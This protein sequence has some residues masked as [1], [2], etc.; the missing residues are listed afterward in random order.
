LN[1]QDSSGA[2]SSSNI[3]PKDIACNPGYYFDYYLGKCVPICPAGYHNDSITGACVLNAP[4]YVSY[5][6]VRIGYYIGNHTL[7]FSSVADV[8]TVLNQLDSDYEQYNTAYEN[9]YPNYNPNQ[10]DSIDSINNF[11][12]LLTYE[13]FE[14]NFSGYISERSS[15]YNIEST[16]L[17]NNMEGIDPDSIDLTYDNSENAICNNTYMVMIAGSTYQW[18]TSGFVQTGGAMSPQSATTCFTNRTKW[19]KPLV[20]SNRAFR[21]KAAINYYIVR[22]SAHGKVV[23]YKQSNGKWKRSRYDLSVGVAGTIYAPDCS[24][25]TQIDLINPASGYKDR[26]ELAVRYGTW[27]ITSAYYTR[28]G[29]LGA[30]FLTPIGHKAQ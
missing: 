30:S 11:D 8:N 7:S 19:A 2:A 25:T 23:S 16:W 5:A 18:T 9:R 21:V 3:S 1:S 27:G 6:G 14:A 15:L 20:V 22:S 29:L 12:N 4:T 17:N 10:M 28:T 13:N 24:T 26:R